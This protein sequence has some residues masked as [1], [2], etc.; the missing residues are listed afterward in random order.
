MRCPFNNG[1]TVT[2][3]GIRNPVVVYGNTFISYGS[4]LNNSYLTAGLLNKPVASGNAVNINK[5]GT[6]DIDRQS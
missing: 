4:S 1:N 6:D 2:T 3:K 5:R